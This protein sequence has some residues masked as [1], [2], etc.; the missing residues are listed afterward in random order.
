MTARVPHERPTTKGY[1]RRF[2]YLR[3]IRV[4]VAPRK[5]L[6]KNVSRAKSHWAFQFRHFSDGDSVFRELCKHRRA[7]WKTGC[8]KAG[9]VTLIVSL[10]EFLD[11]KLWKTISLVDYKFIQ[12]LANSGSQ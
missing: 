10:P 11:F 7:L 2:Y 6:Y 1:F 9:G 8:G 3:V 4:V 5:K 12:F